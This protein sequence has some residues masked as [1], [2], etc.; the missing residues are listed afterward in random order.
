M[1]D[2]AGTIVERRR[3]A[4]S[5]G[6]PPRCT[7]AA[8]HGAA[9]GPGRRPAEERPDPRGRRHQHAA[10]RRREA[11]RQARGALDRPDHRRR[12]RRRVRGHVGQRDLRRRQRLSLGWLRSSSRAARYGSS[13]GPLRSADASRISLAMADVTLTPSLAPTGSRPPAGCRREGKV[14]AV[15][16]GLGADAVVGHR[17]APASCEHILAGEAGANTLITLDARRR[18]ASSPSP[19]RS[20]ATRCRATLVHVDF[21]RVA[22]RRRGR[23]PRSRS[24]SMGEAEGVQRRRHARAA[25]LHTSPS[26]PSRATSRRRS[27]IDVSALEIGD[28]L[29]VGDLAAAR[30]ASP[31]QH[32]PDDARR[33]GRRRPA[34][35]TEATRAKRPR[36]KRA[37]AARARAARRRRRRPRTTSGRG[38]VTACCGERR[39]HR[40][41]PAGGRARQPRRRVRAARATTSAPRSSSCWRARHGGQLQ[42][43]KE[44]ALRRRGAHRR[45]AGRARDPAHLHERLRARR[46]APLVRR[47]GVEPDQ[48]VIVHDE[49]DLPVGGAEGEGRRRAGRPQRPA[50]DQAHLHTDE[51]VRVRI[52]VGKPPSQGA[53]APTTCSAGSPSASAS[54]IDVTSRR[55]PTRSS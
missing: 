16:Y 45:Q 50:V 12:H 33:A 1:I 22:P 42:K 10:D 19:A 9:L 2:T 55:P 28:Q 25:A 7:I 41:R 40:R 8:T 29:H 37:R 53:A 6:A 52:G 39:G 14:P 21:V 35:S 47:Y 3:A 11:V 26:R 23:A 31:S 34:S 15:V 54:E 49:L 38:E 4:A 5:T 20:S 43:G 51:F 46:C 32:E 27:S 24:T 48:L 44:R 36:A 13:N 30:P 18:R 17:R